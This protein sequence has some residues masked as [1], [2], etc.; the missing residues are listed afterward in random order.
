MYVSRVR[1][2]RNVYIYGNRP[3]V[4]TKPNSRGSVGHDVSELEDSV[5]GEVVEE[6]DVDGTLARLVVDHERELDAAEVSGEHHRLK[7][8]ISLLLSEHLHTTISP[9]HHN[10]SMSV[11]F[12]PLLLCFMPYPYLTLS[13]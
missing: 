5:S 2:C 3:L 6:D 13:L 1:R 4:S 9:Y 10:S 8:H 11:T 7:W 12:S